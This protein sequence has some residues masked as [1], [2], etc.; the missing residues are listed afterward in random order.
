M[1]R[2]KQEVKKVLDKTATSVEDFTQA[3][4]V[5]GDDGE[6]LNIHPRAVQEMINHRRQMLQMLTFTERLLRKCGVRIS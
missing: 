2:R 3:E 4:I 1:N 6:K 5:E